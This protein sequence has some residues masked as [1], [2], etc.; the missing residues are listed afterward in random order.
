[1]I[2]KSRKRMTLSA[3]M[4]RGDRLHTLQQQ[5][6]SKN[7]QEAWHDRKLKTKILKVG[8]LAFLYEIWTKDKPRKLEIAWLGPFV[9]EDI[10]PSWDVQPKT[11]QGNIFKSLVN[12]VWLKIHITWQHPHAIGENLS[13]GLG[14]WASPKTTLW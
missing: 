11:S 8:D 6:V 5:E 3:T 14:T 7:Q 12:C 4:P 9:V 13:E 1:M 2:M 10:Y